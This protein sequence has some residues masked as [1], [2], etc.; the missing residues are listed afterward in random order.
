MFW[1]GSGGKDEPRRA[2]SGE[3]TEP[4]SS[5]AAGPITIERDAPRPATILRVASELERRGENVI[6]LFTEIESPRGQAVLPI[7]VRRE[8]GEVFIAV[9]TSPWEIEVVD[10]IL[11]AAAVLRSSEYS[12]AEV[13]VLG[14]YPVP[15]EVLFFASRDPGA[16]FQLDLF[17][18]DPSNPESAAERFRETAGKRWGVDLDYDPEALPLVE[19]LLIAALEEPDER[20][21]SPPPVLDAL[22]YSLGA[23]VGET[24]R[25]QTDESGSWAAAAD[26]GEGRILEF[27]TF[28]ADP[29]GQARAFLTQDEGDSLYFYANYVLK[30]LGAAEE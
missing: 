26:W 17:G 28:T 18:A 11:K 7:R 2:T 22:V 30:E 29:V 20:T 10:G 23:Y 25:R 19:E 9:E 15:D 12:D 21:A 16:L 24:I 13:V 3:G 14:A 6:E 27:G 5:S 1:S 8:K 4:G